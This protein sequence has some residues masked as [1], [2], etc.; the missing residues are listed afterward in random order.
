VVPLN[1]LTPRAKAG[2]AVVRRLKKIL[3]LPARGRDLML[4]RLRFKGPKGETVI[5]FDE[6]TAPE[7]AR[8]LIAF[9]SAQARP[10]MPV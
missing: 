3:P 8:P 2:L 1:S 7:K 4:Y 9:L 6:K 10:F 5:H